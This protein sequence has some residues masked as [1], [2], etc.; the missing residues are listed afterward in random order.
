MIHLEDWIQ[1]PAALAIGRT[2]LHSLW[3]ALVAAIVLAACLPFIKKSSVRYGAACMALI[4]IVASSFGTFLLVIPASGGRAQFQRSLFPAFAVSDPGLANAGGEPSLSMFRTT[5][6]WITPIWLIGVFLLN[7]R[8]VASWFGTRRMWRTGVCPIDAWQERL[9][10]MRRHLKVAKPVL[11][12]ESAVARIPQVVGHIRPVIVLPIGVLTGLTAEQVE[13]ILMHELAHIHRCDY[14]IN[15][16]QT[17]IESI[18]FFNPAVWWISKVIRTEREH[19]CDDI[20]VAATNSARTYAAALAALEEHRSSR[21]QLAI[22]A[23][24]GSLVKRIRRVLDQPETAASR[25]API[26]S[27]ALIISIVTA[28]FLT[29]RPH[30]AAESKPIR[31]VAPVRSPTAPPREPIVAQRGGQRNSFPPEVRI[32]EFYQRWLDEDVAYIIS[33]EERMAFSSLRTDPERDAFMEQFWRRRDPTPG[34]LEN[35]FKKEHYLRIGYANGKFMSAS[36]AGWQTDR[37]RIYIQ[38]GP[39]HEI[40]SHPSGGTYNRPVEQGGG[41]T[42]TFPFEIWRYRYIQGIGNDVLIEFTDPTGTGEFTQTVDPA[43]KRE[44]IGK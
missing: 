13:L 4:T 35:E 28:G 17:L 12:L 7:L 8:Q 3:Q 21:A 43:A 15:V 37:G 25:V 32:Q 20:V 22:A 2:L 14:L 11:L 34:T 23:T 33:N 24:G 30:V 1:T 36:R 16:V 5:L 31:S 27:A 29:A 39:P 40:E 10:S 9:N 26:L 41:T 44:L 6:P 42:R 19:C 38:F 18:M